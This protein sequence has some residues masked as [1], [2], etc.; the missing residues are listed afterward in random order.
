MSH[1]RAT[2]STG[3]ASLLIAAGLLGASSTGAAAAESRT[4]TVNIQD[5]CDPTTF[6][7]VLGAGACVGNGDTTFASFLAELTKK[8]RVGAWRFSPD[9]LDLTPGTT[10]QAVNRGGETHTF[11]EV[12]NFG[13]GVVPLLNTL[14]GN[15]VMA[16]E[17][18]S[19][20]FI[21]AG[22]VFTEQ[23]VPKPGETDLYQCCI[24]PWMRAAITGKRS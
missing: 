15:P 1:R 14:S 16:P 2:I 7:A 23:D 3:L 21:P 4:R 5:D 13:G 12:A 24:H 20:T 11:T 19:A 9:K 8:Q 22:G 10:L 18:G 6:N 17:C